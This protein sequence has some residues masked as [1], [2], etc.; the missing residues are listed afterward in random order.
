MYK[1]RDYTENKLEI[2]KVYWKGLLQ[3]NTQ[4]LFSDIKKF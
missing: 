3:I 2:L 1:L 4:N